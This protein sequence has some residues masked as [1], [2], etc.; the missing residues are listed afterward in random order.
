MDVLNPVQDMFGD[1]Q[2][3][4]L[5]SSRIREEMPDDTNI[6][7][8][9]IAE[10]D[11]AGI[12]QQIN[13]INQCRPKV[14]GIDSFF[15][16]LK[17]NNPHGDSLLANAFS[18]TENL[19]LV[20][21]LHYQDSLNVFDSLETS[22]PIF[23]KNAMTGSANLLTEGEEKFRTAREFC[24]YDTIATGNKRGWIEPFFAVKVAE[25]YR[26]GSTQMVKSRGN[27]LETILYRGNIYGT[28]AKFAVIDAQDILDNN[29]LPEFLANKIVL[30]G[31]MG[32]E[33]GTS[34]NIWDIDKFFTPLNDKYVG[35]A[36]PDMY[37]IVVHANIVSMI[38]NHHFV[39]ESDPWLDF[40]LGFLF[41]FSSV[42]AFNFALNW[43]P[44]LFDPI[45]KVVQLVLILVLIY[46]EVQIYR[47]SYFRVDFGIALAAIALAPDL[48]EIYL[49]IIKRFVTFLA[50]KTY[51]H[52]KII[53][54]K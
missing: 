45:T 31:Y 16:R 48:L 22:H 26:P 50:E 39:D 51:I 36:I 30:M 40:L 33:L 17:P 32:R 49:H 41:C 54:E 13:I 19:I 4:D 42:V 7:I 44:Q 53:E 35:K 18:E 20:S 12:A 29:F 2:L 14:I 52:K 46:I 38:L 23:M 11:R 6:V 5:V 24:P 15:R 1:F 47:K 43:A 37:G 27:E 34:E 21:K 28:K 8:I 10:L 25:V 9:N 3:T